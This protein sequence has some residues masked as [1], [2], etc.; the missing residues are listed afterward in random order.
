MGGYGSGGHNMRKSSTGYCPKIDSF[1]FNRIIPMMSEEDIEQKVKKVEW[2]NGAKI[3]LLVYQS[4]I[5]VDYRYQLNDYDEWT[6]VKEAIY[7][8]ELSNNFGGNR[9]YFIC[10]SCR[11]RFRFL[12]IR[13][14]YFRCR[15]CNRLNYPT[16]RKGK[17]DLPSIKMQTILSNKFK[18]K[19]KDL[20]YFDMADYIPDKP[21]G[22][23]WNTYYKWL[24][25]LEKAQEEYDTLIMSRFYSFSSK[26]L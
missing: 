11:N 20:S 18:I 6:N 5:E 2:D 25:E 9:L 15:K 12:Y 19:I 8:S 1:W 16:S 24:E 26:Y 21:K 14:G 22:M 13:S 10:P 17:N 3:T 23:H 7:L 4:K